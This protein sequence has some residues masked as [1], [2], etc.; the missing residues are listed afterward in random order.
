MLMLARVQGWR[1]WVSVEVGDT[2]PAA[3]LQQSTAVVSRSGVWVNEQRQGGC[4]K[5][6]CDDP[7]PAPTR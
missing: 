2:F 3:T 4:D 7:F 1:A 6:R 5:L